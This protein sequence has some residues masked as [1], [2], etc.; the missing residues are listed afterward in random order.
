MSPSKKTRRKKSKASSIQPRKAARTVFFCVLVKVMSS[1]PNRHSL[2]SRRCQRHVAS[3]VAP[4]QASLTGGRSTCF[5]PP[6]RVGQGGKVT[7]NAHESVLPSHLFA[8]DAL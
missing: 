7:A 1:P 3:G 4:W 2:D 5:R 8:R 6:I